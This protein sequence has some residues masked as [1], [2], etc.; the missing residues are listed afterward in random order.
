LLTILIATVVY[1]S[2]TDD[3]A[4]SGMSGAILKPLDAAIRR[5]LALYYPSGRQGT[6]TKQQGK[7]DQL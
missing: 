4:R 3:I 5:L 7:M 1:Q 2:N 6:Q